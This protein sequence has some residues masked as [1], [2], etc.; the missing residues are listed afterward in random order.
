MPRF[1][2]MGLS[3]MALF[4]IALSACG[5]NTYG[6]VQAGKLTIASDTTYP[7]AESIDSTKSGADSFVGYDMDLGRELA[8]QAAAFDLQSADG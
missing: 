5:G 6:I 4:S 1:W 7:P 8:K 2:V 3:V